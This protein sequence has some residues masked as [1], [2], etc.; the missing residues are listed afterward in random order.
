MN[1]EKIYVF[2][3][4]GTLAESKG[5]I[6]NQMRCLLP[7][8]LEKRIVCVVSG[9]RWKQFQ[10]QLID[11]LKLD[12]NLLK[13][14]HCF[15][16]SG[17]S[18]Y[19]YDT[20]KK[21]W[22]QVYSHGLSAAEK[23]RIKAV[24]IQTI[25][26]LPDRPTTLW[27][28]TIE[29]RQTQITYS[30]LGQLAPIEEKHKWDPDRSKR[31]WMVEQMQDQLSNFEIRIGGTTSIDITKPGIH[32]G[33]A[34]D[35]ICTHMQCSKS[36]LIFFGDALEPGGNDYEVYKTGVLSVPVLSHIDCVWK[37]KQALELGW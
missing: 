2:D 21:D 32:K 36:D 28:D 1:K 6:D 25:R 10:D 7:E 4:D 13:W 9:G 5:P 20:D 33:Y 14:L 31:R 35:Q 34:V 29:D 23:L 11:Q 12:S 24:L 37:V 18:Y 17:A 15:P 22:D 30:A 26:Q 8:L 16:T 3:L 19:R 27:G